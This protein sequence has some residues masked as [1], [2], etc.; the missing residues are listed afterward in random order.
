MAARTAGRRWKRF[1]MDFVKFPSLKWNIDNGIKYKIDPVIGKF[2][3]LKE[4]NYLKI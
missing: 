3:K 1:M 2:R 4:C